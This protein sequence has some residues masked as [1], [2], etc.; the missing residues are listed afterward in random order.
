MP[1]QKLQNI[2]VA[3]SWFYITWSPTRSFLIR[4]SQ[5]NLLLGVT[6]E[7]ILFKPSMN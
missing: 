4:N 7:L 1:V 6:P 5:E 3:A 2:I